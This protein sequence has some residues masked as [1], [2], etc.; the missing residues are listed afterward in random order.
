MTVDVAKVP[1][2]VGE[3]ER[4]TFAA[5][6]GDSL[7]VM[8]QRHR[9]VIHIPLDLA[10]TRE[11]PRQIR[12]D[13]RLATEIDRMRQVPLGVVKPF[14]LARLKCL[15]NEFFRCIRHRG[16]RLSGIVFKAG[17]SRSPAG[18][19]FRPRD[20]APQQNFYTTRTA[21]CDNRTSS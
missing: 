17:S 14:F 11:R 19:D 21:K 6:N 9:K 12:L 3:P 5:V 10:K 1:N 18:C 4:I 13:A 20:E 8:A 2:R 16:P 7:F 15:P